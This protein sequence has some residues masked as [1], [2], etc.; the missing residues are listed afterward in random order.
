M[1]T[2]YEDALRILHISN[3]SG[4]L[5]EV[6]AKMIIQVAQTSERDPKRIRQR[7]LSNLGIC[8]TE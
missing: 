4:S 7:A 8:A 1:T 2:A 3:R 5:C 6:L